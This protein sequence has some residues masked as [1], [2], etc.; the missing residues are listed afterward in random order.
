MHVYTKFPIDWQNI[1]KIIPRINH[2]SA[3]GE[4]NIISL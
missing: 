1:W 3:L 4:I 2:L